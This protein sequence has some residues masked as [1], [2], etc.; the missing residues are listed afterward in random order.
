MKKKDLLKELAYLDDNAEI[1]IFDYDLK[2]Y[3][4][5]DKVEV[6]IKDG[7]KVYVDLVINI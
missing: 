2:N 4:D 6:R 3:W 5:I 1:T 7:M